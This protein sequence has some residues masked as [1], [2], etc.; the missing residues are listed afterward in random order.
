M[1][2]EETSEGFK[3]VGLDG[4]E[5]SN[6]PYESERKAKQ[7]FNAHK[8]G[9]SGDKEEE[10]E[11]DDGSSGENSGSI[12]NNNREDEDSTFMELLGNKYVIIGVLGAG[13][14]L[15]LKDRDSEAG[16]V[17]SD[18]DVS[19]SEGSESTETDQDNLD[20]G[21]MSAEELFN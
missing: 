9:Y 2:I 4:N 17:E 16:N 21:R 11:D 1:G 13:A 19:D 8:M 10:E 20:S 6:S 18:Q 7:A 5:L 15:L 14:Y 12:E 3:V